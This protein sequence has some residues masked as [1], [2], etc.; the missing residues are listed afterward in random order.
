VYHSVV[1]ARAPS[2]FTTITSHGARDD[3]NSLRC[4][5]VSNR[6]R[7]RSTVAEDDG[8]VSPFIVKMKPSLLYERRKRWAPDEATRHTRARDA[9]RD[10]VA[11]RRATV[12]IIAVVLARSRAGRVARTSRS[13][14]RVVLVSRP[15]A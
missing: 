1:R 8:E 2:V 6:T 10:A 7:V 9:R 13:T 4:T 11:A 5:S 3:E 15:I 14:R 12:I